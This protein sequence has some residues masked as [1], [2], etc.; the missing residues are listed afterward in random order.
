MMEFDGS[1]L[2]HVL[3]LPYRQEKTAA[4]AHRQICS[5]H[6]SNAI[7]ESTCCKWFSNF[8]EPDF[9]FDDMKDKPKPSPAKKMPDDELEAL[10]NEDPSQTEWDLA[11]QLGV[12]QSTI[13]LRLKELGYVPKEGVLHVLICAPCVNATQHASTCHNCCFFVF[14]SKKEE[15]SVQ[16]CD[17]RQDPIFFENPEPQ[18]Y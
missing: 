11:M 15:L 18:H 14:S 8:K 6:D 9:H 10:F 7:G 1:Y 12:N 5:L 2:R 16:D 4:D 13:S 17:W 3:L